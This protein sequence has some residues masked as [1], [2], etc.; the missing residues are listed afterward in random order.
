MSLMVRLRRSRNH[1]H[2]ETTLSWLM[3]MIEVA[4]FADVAIVAR[5]AAAELP[6]MMPLH[7]YVASL[8]ELQLRLRC[9]CSAGALLN[10]ADS[11][12]GR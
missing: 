7:C 2:A 10:A 9:S 12:S 6:S 5:V 11:T 4:D 3:M 1:E 8:T